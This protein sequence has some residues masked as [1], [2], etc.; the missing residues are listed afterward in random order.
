MVEFQ[1]PAEADYAVKE[2]NGVDYSGGR[3]LMITLAN[4]AR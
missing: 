4:A 1:T 2:L 3:Q